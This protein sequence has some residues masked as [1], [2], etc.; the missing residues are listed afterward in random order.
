[1]SECLLQLLAV[2]Q[3][4]PTRV[5]RLPRNSALDHL[6]QSRGTLV[7]QLVLD[8]TGNLRDLWDLHSE[9]LDKFFRLGQPLGLCS[10][11]GFRFLQRLLCLVD[12]NVVLKQPLLGPPDE[13]FCGFD[14]V[15]QGRHCRWRWAFSKAT[16]RIDISSVSSAQSAAVDALILDTLSVAAARISCG[17]T[18]GRSQQEAGEEPHVPISSYKHKQWEAQSSSS[19]WWNWQGSWKSSYDSESHE[20]GEPSTE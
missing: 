7:L 19:T 6:H 11:H 8:G 9:A 20:G 15:V 13:I 14:L 2:W 17:G 1:M 12:D 10:V 18:L 3:I 16:C 5:A 4:V